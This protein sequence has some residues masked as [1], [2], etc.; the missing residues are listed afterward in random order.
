MSS[1]RDIILQRIGKAIEEGRAPPRS[2]RESGAE[3]CLA[4][5]ENVLVPAGANVSGDEAIALFTQKAQSVQTTIRHVA[6]ISDVAEAVSQYLTAKNLPQAIRRGSDP[7]L[8]R[9]GW[10]AQ[11]LMEVTIGPSDGSDRVGLSVAVSAVA[12]TGTLILS[13][14]PD[15][16]TTLNFLP[17]H[18]LVVLSAARIVGP[19]EEALRATVAEAGPAGILPRIVNLITGPSRSGDVEQ[20]IVLGAHGPRA[21]HVI[22]IGDHPTAV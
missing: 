3:A 13:S 21:V 17:D 18:H 16:P 10:E 7:L 19:L 6:A 5:K 20:Q 11:P 8:D 4:A 9:A 12:E 22:L 1:A 15:N 2:E 14:G